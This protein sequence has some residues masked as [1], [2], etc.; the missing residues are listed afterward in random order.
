MVIGGLSQGS[1]LSL[2]TGSRF[3]HRLAG[4]FDMS[5][6]LLLPLLLQLSSMIHIEQRLSL[7]PWRKRRHRITRAGNDSTG[8]SAKCGA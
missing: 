1:A 7:G 4:I 2:M 3:R 5:G 8:Y 6:Y